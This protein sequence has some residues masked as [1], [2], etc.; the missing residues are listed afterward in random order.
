[1]PGLGAL[2]RGG[3]AFVGSVSCGSAGNCAAGGYYTDSGRHQQG[4]VVSEN[5]GVWGPATGVP[6]LAALNRG[7]GAEVVSVSCGSTGNCVA[8]GYYR[9]RLRRSQGFVVSEKNGVWGRATGV[10]DLGALDTSGYAEVV[11]VSCASAGYCAAGGDYAAGRSYPRGFVVSE[12]NGVWGPATGVPGLAALSANGDAGLLSVSCG[13]AGNCTAGGKYTDGSGHQQ[14]FVVSEHNGV[15][16]QATVVPGLGA[17]NAHGYAEVMS[18]SCA[19]A[20]NCAAG[21]SYASA[22]PQPDGG[23]KEQGFV[24][25]EHNGVWGQATGVPGLAALNTNGSAYVGSVSCASPASCAASG[26]YDYDYPYGFVVIEKNGVWGQAI[27]VPGLQALH[28]GRQVDVNSVSCASPG[29]C[30][31]G[32]DGELMNGFLVSARNGV[33]GRAINVPGLQALGGSASVAS[34]SCVPAGNCAAGGSY[35][36]GH[37]HSQGFVT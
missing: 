35:T 12:N 27:N 15:W 32:G 18:V 10:A 1:V 11:S 7:G 5:D 30:A 33:W 19:S 2:N 21:G 34:V 17:L 28:A 23:Y 8:G 37:G 29:N 26:D 24:V 4:F 16:G 14:G 31:A 25:S 36:D 22:V 9:D 20:G 6:G 13:S 3:D